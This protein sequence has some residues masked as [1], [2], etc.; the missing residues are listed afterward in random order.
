MAPLFKMAGVMVGTPAA[1]THPPLRSTW[2]VVTPSGAAEVLEHMAQVLR[3]GRGRI[4]F[5]DEVSAVQFH[6]A[7]FFRARI[8]VGSR[9]ARLRIDLS[10][11][12]SEP[13]PLRI[14]AGE[15]ASP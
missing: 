13:L 15:S 2:D 6:R 7:L 3:T 12:T 11:R 10:W 9:R 1:G 4:R 8:A 14:R 5:D